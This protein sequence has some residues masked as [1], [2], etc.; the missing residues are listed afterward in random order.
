MIQPVTCHRAGRHASD[1]VNTIGVWI[2]AGTWGSYRTANRGL[3]TQAG[4]VF[5]KKI[6]NSD[7]NEPRQENWTQEDR[8]RAQDPRVRRLGFQCTVIKQGLGWSC[9]SIGWSEDT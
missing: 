6:L 8:D 9:S 7:V 5:F 3:P 1:K 2:I 4:G